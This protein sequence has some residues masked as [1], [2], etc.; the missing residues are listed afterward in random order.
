MTTIPTKVAFVGPGSMGGPLAAHPGRTGHKA[1]GFD[2]IPG[3][4]DQTRANGPC[5][6]YAE[7][8]R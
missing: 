5:A 3:A 8:T 7:V 1:T 6:G 4:R 2:P